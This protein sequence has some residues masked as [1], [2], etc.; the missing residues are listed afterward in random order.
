[1]MWVYLRERWSLCSVQ[2][3]MISIKCCRSDSLKK[4]LG[5]CDPASPGSVPSTRPGVGLSALSERRRST[6]AR[7]PFSQ[8]AAALW[9]SPSI[10]ATEGRDTNLVGQTESAMMRPKVNSFVTPW[11]KIKLL[12]M[13]Y[14]YDMARSTWVIMILWSDFYTFYIFQT[15][16][17][18]FHSC[19]TMVWK[20][21]NKLISE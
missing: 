15:F 11:L 3:S 14:Y 21:N 16:E 8:D 10:T 1:M 4:V 7:V 12:M 19:V 6:G 9:P 17:L 13:Y 18:Q 5:E 20:D 2:I